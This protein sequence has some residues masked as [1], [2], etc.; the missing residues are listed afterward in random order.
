MRLLE[1]FELGGLTLPNR[2]VMAPMTRS[3]APVETADGQTA[4][5]YRQRA[6]AGLIVSEGIPISP[7]AVG[8]SF[9]PGLS[10]RQQLDGW[11]GVTDAVHDAG[12]RIYAQLWHVGRVSHTSLQPQGLAPVSS[13]SQPAVGP[14]V[15]AYA[16]REDGSIGFVPPSA[17]RALATEEVVRVVADYGRAAHRALEV[18]FDGVEIHGAHGYLVEQF[19]N[20]GINDR[21]DQ[22]G[23]SPGA[24]RRFLLEVLDAVSNA[25]GPARVGIR[26]SPKAQLLGAPG[27]DDNEATYLAAFA[28]LD[29]RGIG[30]LHLSDTGARAGNAAMTPAFLSRVRETYRGV[31]VL[32]GSLTAESAERRIADGLIDLAAFGQPFIANPDLVA[33]IALRAEW[34]KPDPATYYGGGAAGY[35]DY[36]ALDP[37]D[38]AVAGGRADRARREHIA[39]RRRKRPARVSSS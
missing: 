17:P 5:Y 35:T 22:Y 7:E 27:Y 18:G 13:S 4:L 14:R 34:A 36:P 30:Y 12:G 37:G 16:P 11:R 3:R 1:R 20:P 23:G 10:S 9:L 39:R 25:I 28:E 6:A 21:T 38:E 31:V 15:F 24:R 33:R 19:L 26:L 2:V 29:R 32:A 8:Y